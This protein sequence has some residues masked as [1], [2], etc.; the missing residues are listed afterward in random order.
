VAR[1]FDQQSILGSYLDPLA[2]KVLIGSVVAALGI[3]VR[4]FRHNATPKP[5][6]KALLHDSSRLWR[7]HHPRH[8]DTSPV[9]AYTSLK[10]YC[11]S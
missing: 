1:R 3:Q 6:V 7:R 11:F 9:P 2:D 8:P 4:L 10:L 5:I